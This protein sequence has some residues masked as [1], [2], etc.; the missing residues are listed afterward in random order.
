MTPRPGSHALAV[1]Q[2][3][4]EARAVCDA[5]RA[6]GAI[7]GFVPTMGALHAGHLALVREARRRAGFVLASIFVNPTQFAPHED[8][9]RYPRDLQGDIDKLRTLGVDAVLAPSVEAMY[10]PGDDTRVHVGAIGAPLEGVFRPAHFDG[11][12]TV[13]TK[14]LGAVGPCV[15]VF[16]RKDYQQLLVV[17]RVVA[18]LFLPVEIVGHRIVREPDGLALSSRNAYLAR[19]ERIR[20]LAIVRGLDAA[21][22][23]YEGGG[24]RNARALERVV[25]ACVEPAATS[26]DYIEARDAETLASIEGDIAGRAVLAVACRVGATRLIDNVVL[27]EDPP[28][29]IGPES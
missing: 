17:R 25:R 26:I 20:A 13:V 29:L 23:R 22:R 18:D 6:R 2:S 4:A 27:G 21:A 9:G 7:V 14:L 11:V 1:L 19:D 28:P 5:A 24:E 16:G 8:L 12:A 15:A 3:P 10:G